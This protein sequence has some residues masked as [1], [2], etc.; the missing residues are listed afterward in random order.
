MKSSSPLLFSFGLSIIALAS[1]CRRADQN[2]TG[3][4]HGG[5]ASEPI[6]VVAA[7]VVAKDTPIYLDS[8]GTVS[9]FNTVTVHSQITGQLQ[10]IAFKEGQDVKAGDL[11]ALIDARALQAQLEVARAR[12][13]EDEAR[14]ANARST[15]ERNAGLLERGLI[16]QQTAD[17]YKSGYEQL[18]AQV[19]ADDA[20]IASAQVQLDYTR[21][22]A[23]INGRTGLRQV[24]P[25]NI[26]HP[27][28]PNGIVVITQLQPISVVFTLPQ[29]QLARLHH[30]TSGDEG[31]LTVQAMD[32]DG[33]TLLD[34]GTLTVVDNQIDPAT[35]TIRL[36]ATL[37]NPRLRLWPGQF[38][39]IRL[40]VDTRH[41]GIVVPASAILRG[42]DGP[43]VFIIKPDSTVDT[44]RVT[45][46][47]IE[48]DTALI[49]NGLKPGEQVVT[50]GQYRL[51]S[52]STVTTAQLGPKP[53]AQSAG[54]PS[55]HSASSSL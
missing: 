7:T 21:I 10:S 25:G 24:D 47:Q 31:G 42:P 33:A 38:I 13:S 50:D 20:G 45:V 54:I 2:H 34:T 8:I 18:R 16:D 9:A 1:S 26:V 28:D 48:E 12:K 35:G 51:Q 36:K 55:A 27:T 32:R 19:Q 46:T 14:L 4:H 15:Y 3:G 49:A 52:G 22:T 43:Y 44:R 17:G 40:L 41:D 37:P 6:P 53:P 5:S 30:A 11:L 39:N 29:Q 23:P